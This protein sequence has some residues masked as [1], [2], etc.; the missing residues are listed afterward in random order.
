MPDKPRGEKVLSALPEGSHFDGVLLASGPVR[1][2][3]S[4][5]GPVIS[6]SSVEIAAAAAIEGPIE[7]Q[8]IQ[9]A[10]RVTGD[11]TASRR[12]ALAATARVVG[13]IAAPRL[14]AEE[15]AQ[16]DGS[17]RVGDLPEAAKA[18]AKP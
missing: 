6:T 11:L 10:G 14:S 12:V 8:E 1:I 4:V 17:A 13:R 15:G 7:A 2:E 5:H 3:G 9:V 18:P 16:V